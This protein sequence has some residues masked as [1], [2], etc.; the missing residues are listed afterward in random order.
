MITEALE[1]YRNHEIKFISNIDG[2]YINGLLKILNPET[3]VFYS[4]KSF[5][6]QETLTNGETIKNGS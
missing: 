6:T 3:T 2:D 5:T 4:I 1:F